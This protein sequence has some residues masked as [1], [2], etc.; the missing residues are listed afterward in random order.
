MKTNKIYRALLDKSVS[1]MLAAIEVYN[2]PNFYYREDSFAILCVNAWELL[3]K[4][5]LLKKNR[6]KMTSLYV[7]I[8][9]KKKDGSRSKHMEPDTNRTGNPKT[10]TIYE[11]I[12]RLK[13]SGL[14]PQPLEDNIDSIIELRDNAIHFANLKPISRTIQE[15]GFATIKNYMNFIKSNNIEIDISQ[16]NFYLMPLA[17]VDSKI[18]VDAVLTQEEKNYVSLIKK[19]IEGKR[20]D[21]D[22]DIAI[23]IDINF[24]KSTSL[25][26]IGVVYDAEGIPVEIKEE[27]FRKR[28]PLSYTALCEKCSTRY[29]DF[30]RNKRFNDVM[31]TIKTD[32]KLCHT[33]KLDDANPKSVKQQFYSSNV[34]KELDK[35]YT[36]K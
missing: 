13:S 19:K 31:R 28:F 34:F 29:T 23:S 30:K 27:D 9:K 33:R 12:G 21:D 3:L 35:V 26:G 16:Y 25:D 17:Y 10:I 24:K 32:S 14:I 18:D 2:K 4:A 7:M 1:S 8:P 20:D 36:K 22:Y 11:V 15:L 6:Y 5:V